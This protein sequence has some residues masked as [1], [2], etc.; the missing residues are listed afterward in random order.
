[1]ASVII[2]EVVDQPPM[3]GSADDARPFDPTRVL[4]RVYRATLRSYERA[5]HPRRHLKITLRLKNQPRPRR[6]LVIC[7]GNIC[8][9]PYLQAVL[10]RRLPDVVVTSAGFVGSG[11]PAPQVSLAV[12]AQRGLDLSGHRSQRITR[13]KVADADLVI[14]MDSEQARRV[15]RRFRANPDRIAIAGDLEPTFDTSRSIRDPW[16]E[17]A[18]VFRASFDRLD[19][20]AD[21]LVGLLQ[22]AR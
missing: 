10:Q 9:S 18:D 13:S 20:C 14:V 22:S 19:R 4:R 11:R 7:H 5:L 12:S 16:K 8:R 17:S 3:R 6:I 21:N 2:V 15:A 1:M